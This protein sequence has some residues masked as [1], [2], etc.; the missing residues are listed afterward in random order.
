MGCLPCRFLY[1]QLVFFVILKYTYIKSCIQRSSAIGMS[2]G[3]QTAQ[4]GSL[5]SGRYGH[6]HRWMPLR[7]VHLYHR[8]EAKDN[9]H[10]A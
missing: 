4:Y 6:A 5:P 10:G 3:P 2:I 8:T 9:R 7:A 1:S